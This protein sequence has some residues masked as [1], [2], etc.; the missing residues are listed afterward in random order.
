MTYRLFVVVLLLGISR[1]ILAAP[2]E[3]PEPQIQH[4]MFVSIDGLRPDVLLRAS[5]PRV[6]DMMDRGSFTL[7]AKTTPAS[8]TL[9]SH[10]SMLTGVTPEVH[11]ILWNADLPLAEPVFP[12]AP[13]L[14]E[15][16]RKAGYSTALVAGKSKFSVFDKPASRDEPAALSWKYITTSTKCG[17][18]EVTQHALEILREHQPDVLFVH[19][20]ECDNVGHA[21]GW[22]SA[23][24]LETVARAD[25][26]I[27]QLLDALHEMKLDDSTMII[28]TSDHGGAGRTH[29]AED[30]RS[31]TIPWIAVGPGIRHNFDLTRLGREQDVTTYDTFATA[32]FVLG[33]PID[34]RIDGKPV[35][36]IFDNQE[37]LISTFQPPMVPATLPSA[38]GG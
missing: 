34:F 3:R 38:S 24:Q 13:T 15:L 6:H 28:V 18:D 14:F 33:I 2:R 12:S 37:M 8:I 17:D 27:G 26:C 32:C 19:L 1:A 7:W 35:R 29:G 20:P 22:G 23:E 16:A 25:A 10:V 9:P 4:V 5:T 36:Q 30:P 11:A 21:A 31:R